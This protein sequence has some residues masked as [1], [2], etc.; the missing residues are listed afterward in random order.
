V[1][2]YEST[3]H[4][5]A[6]LRCGCVDSAAE[7]L[8]SLPHCDQSDAGARRSRARE[9][10][11]IVRHHDM[12]AI[13][14]VHEM[15][16]GGD[17]PGVAYD[18]DEAFVDD[19]MHGYHGALRHVVRIRALLGDLDREITTG[20]VRHDVAQVVRGCRDRSDRDGLFGPQESE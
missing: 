2:G 10:W 18:V 4:E 13:I 1:V 15:N 19:A 11:G 12:H 9:E 16:G 3:D 5:P 20:R 6:I 17:L 7:H 14:T 8:C